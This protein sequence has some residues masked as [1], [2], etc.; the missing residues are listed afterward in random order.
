MRYIKTALLLLSASVWAAFDVHGSENSARELGAEEKKQLQ[1]E[2]SD[3]KKEFRSIYEKIEQLKAQLQQ[4][5]LPEHKDDAHHSKS[6]T[7]G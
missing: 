6:S 5:S 3:L 2:V 7:M 4:A 1:L